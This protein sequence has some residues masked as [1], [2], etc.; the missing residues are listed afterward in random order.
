[1]SK[2]T[3]WFRCPAKSLSANSSSPFRFRS[4][5]KEFLSWAIDY[6]S[7]WCFRLMVR[8]SL[9]VESRARL[10]ATDVNCE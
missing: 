1:M 5:T 2:L 10:M 8:S 6:I 3:T 4:E 9:V 7:F